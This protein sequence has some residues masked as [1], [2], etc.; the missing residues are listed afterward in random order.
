MD[1][2]DF[3]VGEFGALSGSGISKLDKSCEPSFLSGR[4]SIV[5]SLSSID[6]ATRMT[7]AFLVDG[8]GIV[9]I[10]L[11]NDV[12]LLSMFLLDWCCR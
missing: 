1:C 2:L 11:D 9:A 6:C 7:E 4:K 3:V 12:S 8:D 5:V 10:S